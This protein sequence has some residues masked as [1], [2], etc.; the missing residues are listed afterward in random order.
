M[1]R[2]SA[3]KILATIIV[4]IV[5]ML[6]LPGVG[7]S[8]LREITQDTLVGVWEAADI[9]RG[10]V[11]RLEIRDNGKHRLAVTYPPPSRIQFL[12][13]LTRASAPGN[14]QVELEGVEVDTGRRINASGSGNASETKGLMILNLSFEPG[15]FIATTNGQ[16]TFVKSDGALIEGLGVAA[17]KA[18]LLIKG[19][20]DEGD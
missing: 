18:K 8:P 1:Q 11:F 17:A 7:V 2:Q 20:K 3:L 12:F 16:V 14:G 15:L 13:F 4:G 6:P 19:K 5:V 10:T 9:F